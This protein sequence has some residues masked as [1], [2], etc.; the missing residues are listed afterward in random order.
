MSGFVKATGDMDENRDLFNSLLGDRGPQRLIN[1]AE[2][3]HS[4][5]HR[6]VHYFLVIFDVPADQRQDLF[7]Q[8]F[9]KIIKGLERIKHCDNIKSWVITIAKNEIF[10]FLQKHV[11]EIRLY[12][13][14]EQSVK[15]LPSA[16]GGGSPLFSPE[17][18]IYSKE[19]RVAFRQ[20]VER[21][22]ESIRR[23]FLMRYQDYMKWREIG[24]VLGLKVDT[25]RKRAEKAR[26]LV[27]K[28]L[29]NRFGLSSPR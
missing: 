9:L 2:E 26:R 23:P 13:S 6:L 27:L 29:Q 12:D 21:L 14:T 4:R 17:R 25:A 10:S 7:N 11:R 16:E 20:S 15:L 1:L 5:Y 3:L 18:E 28:D 8:I 19:L 24:S 22:A